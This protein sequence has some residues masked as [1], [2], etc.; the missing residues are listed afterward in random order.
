MKK[1]VLILLTAALLLCTAA[2]LAELPRQCPDCGADYDNGWNSHAD[3]RG[4]HC[5]C[6]NC[7]YLDSVNHIHAACETCGYAT[8]CDLVFTH[9]EGTTQHRVICS[10]GAREGICPQDCVQEQVWDCMKAPN[11]AYSVTCRCGVTYPPR[12][13]EPMPYI[14]YDANEHYYPC[15]WYCDTRLNAAP[16]TNVGGY[17]PACGYIFNAEDD[18]VYLFGYEAGASIGGIHVDDTY[19]QFRLNTPTSYHI[20][21]GDPADVFSAAPVR[22]GRFEPH[23]QYWLLVQMLSHYI[24]ESPEGGYRLNL[25]TSDV[26]QTPNEDG[27]SWVAFRLEPLPEPPATP[28]PAPTVPATGDNASLTLWLAALTLAAAGLLV[29]RRALRKA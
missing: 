27:L 15:R 6:R 7:G 12:Q 10:V 11:C 29:M 20:V 25:P 23:K 14:W 24:G 18:M 9:I 19:M 4:H 28:T 17:C 22:S 26:Q 5:R 2:A 16:H 21:E 3:S 1:Y 13:H 8:D